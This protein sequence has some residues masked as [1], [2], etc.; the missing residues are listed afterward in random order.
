MYN[1]HDKINKYIVLLVKILPVTERA[2]PLALAPRIAKADHS[3][4]LAVEEVENSR[5]RQ[6]HLADG[7]DSVGVSFH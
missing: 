4:L 1:F 6:R 3:K 2:S 5:A 7:G